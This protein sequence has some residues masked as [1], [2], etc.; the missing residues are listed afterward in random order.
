MTDFATLR[1]R[2]EAHTSQQSDP[3]AEKRVAKLTETAEEARQFIAY[4]EKTRDEQPQR[5]AQ[6]RAEA[7]EAREQSMLIEPWAEQLTA[8][9]A[10][11]R[12]GQPTAEMLILPNMSAKEMFGGRLAFD[13]LD[14][15]DDDSGERINDVLTRLFT[16]VGG[17]TGQ[18]MLI[19][20]SALDTIASHVMPTLLDQI[21]QHASNWEVRV[22]LAEARTNAWRASLT[23]ERHTTDLPGNPAGK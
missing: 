10:H 21:E 23:D 17:D 9:R 4:V 19:L 8:L 16:M 15:A 5:L 22:T 18:A 3:D 7:D 13:A 20:A 12:D 14:C 2:L 11:R 6:A 1:A